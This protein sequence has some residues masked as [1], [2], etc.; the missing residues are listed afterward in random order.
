V[1]ILSLAEVIG[2]QG[3]GYVVTPGARLYLFEDSPFLLSGALPKPLLPRRIL[4]LLRAGLIPGSVAKWANGKAHRPLHWAAAMHRISF[5]RA[6]PR[7]SPLE[8]R[9]TEA[10]AT[11][12]RVLPRRELA[13]S[14]DDDARIEG[15]TDLANLERWLDRA[16]T[17]VSASGALE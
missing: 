17:A 15:C 13:P 9:L 11:L 12:R 4:K 10:H 14:K 8:G 16:V 3:D 7:R 5:P 1:G 6:R 2:R